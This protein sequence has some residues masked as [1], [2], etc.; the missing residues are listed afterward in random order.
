MNTRFSQVLKKDKYDPV[1][2]FIETCNYNVWFKNRKS[3]DTT[4][5]DRDGSLNLSDMLPIEG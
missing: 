5:N 2:L 4:K 1:D 3:A